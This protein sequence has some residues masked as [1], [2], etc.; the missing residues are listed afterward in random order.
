MVERRAGTVG[1]IVQDLGVL[2]LEVPFC[3]LGLEGISTVVQKEAFAV[4]GRWVLLMN[5]LGG[6]WKNRSAAVYQSECNS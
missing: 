5:G 3:D 4:S 1:W 2:L 6:F